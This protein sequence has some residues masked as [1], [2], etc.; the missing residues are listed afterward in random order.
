VSEITH[1]EIF[2]AP[3]SSENSDIAE[4]LFAIT[5]AASRLCGVLAL[6]SRWLVAGLMA[7]NFHWNA[8]LSRLSLLFA[9]GPFARIDRTVD[10]GVLSSDRVWRKQCRSGTAG[11]IWSGDIG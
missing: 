11:W 1:R 4:A 10:R 5:R 2:S 7:M 6:A 3:R 8:I 9:R